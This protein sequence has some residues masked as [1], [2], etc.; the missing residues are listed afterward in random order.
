MRSIKHLIPLGQ[1][2]SRALVTLALGGPIG[3]HAGITDTSG[4]SPPQNDTFFGYELAEIPLATVTENLRIAES[5]VDNSPATARASEAADLNEPAAQ[6]NR[7]ATSPNRAQRPGTFEVDEDAAARALERTLI[8]TGVLLLTAGNAELTTRLAFAR[9]DDQ[10]T[11][12]LLINESSAPGILESRTRTTEATVEVRVGLPADSQFEI[13]FPYVDIDRRDLVRVGDA[14]PLESRTGDAGWGD[15]TLAYAKTLLRE[16]E[17]TPDLIGRIIWDTNSSR[18]RGTGTGF[19]EYGVS[20][21]AS[22]RHDPVVYNATL[23]YLKSEEKNTIEP[24]NIAGF[25]F[26]AYLAASP[27]TSLWLS[28]EQWFQSDTKVSGQRIPGSD[29]V[30]SNVHFGSAIALDGRNFLNLSA[31]VG[32]TNATSDLALNLAWSRRF[33]FK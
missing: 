31:G 32:L 28:I 3:I 11:I 12:A 33:A 30:L 5:E 2:L 7:P 19:D 16:S 13:A 20:L 4:T 21:S 24:G 27:K 17:G 9:R 8:Q 29:R 14:S 18:D 6:A 26:A 22:L 25:S 23:S 1:Q 15:V 10:T